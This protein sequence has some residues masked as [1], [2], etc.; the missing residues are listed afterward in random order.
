MD[1][2]LLFLAA[3]LC[4]AGVGL[5][6]RSARFSVPTRRLA[7]ALAL[8][9]EP[10]KAPTNGS[11]LS[12]GRQYKMEEVRLRAKSLGSVLLPKGMAEPTLS[13]EEQIIIDRKD[14]SQAEQSG[15]SDIDILREELKRMLDSF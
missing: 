11:A 5:A 10:E 9:A 15:K 6:W 13:K 4:C 7:L 2:R 1:P 14:R 8:A 12:T 3:L